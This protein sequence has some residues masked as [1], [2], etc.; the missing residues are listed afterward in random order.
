DQGPI[1]MMI[2]N[3]RRQAV[4]TRFMQNTDILHGMQVATFTFD[5]V[6]AM[7]PVPGL[8]LAQNMPNPFPEQT[9]IRFSLTRAGHVRL[10]LFD[11]AGRQVA[12]LIDGQR[13]AGDGE[14]RLDA[15][16]LAGGVYFYRLATPEGTSVRRCVVLR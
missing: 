2:E 14:V 8:E 11:L 7:P 1:I 16:A 6:S 9:T 10:A 12:T 5:V 4:W 3:Y 13:P 15:R